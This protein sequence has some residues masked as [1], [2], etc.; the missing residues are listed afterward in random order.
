[1]TM[2]E[3]IEQI[4]ALLDR[5]KPGFA[6]EQAFY[7]SR[8]IFDFEREAILRDNWYMA[9]HVSRIPKWGIISSG[10]L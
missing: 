6:L 9:G 8:D 3:N 2:A 7:V 5:Q 1:M 4:S 10:K